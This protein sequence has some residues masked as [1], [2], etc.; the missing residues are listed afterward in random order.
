MTQQKFELRVILSFVHGS[1]FMETEREEVLDLASHL[2]QA[3]VTEDELPYVREHYTEHVL[4][5]IKDGERL[6]TILTLDAGR[7]ATAQK[8]F[9]KMHA[10]PP[11][12]EG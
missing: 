3:N 5:N 7:Y 2:V 6:T 4:S 8:L 10:I 12:V 1:T 9:G 11:A